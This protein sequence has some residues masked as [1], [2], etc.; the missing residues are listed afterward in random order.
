MLRLM[1]RRFSQWITFFPIQLK[2]KYYPFNLIML[3]SHY[4]FTYTRG[5]LYTKS[6]FIEV[7]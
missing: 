6:A 7:S 3:F 5:F 4:A 2:Y 1:I